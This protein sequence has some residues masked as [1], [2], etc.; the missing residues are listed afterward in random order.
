MSITWCLSLLL[1]LSISPIFWNV[2]SFMEQPQ[3]I[4]FFNIALVTESLHCQKKEKKI[5]HRFC[6]EKW[7]HLNY[8]VTYKMYVIQ[9]IPFLVC[10]IDWPYS[11]NHYEQG[12]I[13][14]MFHVSTGLFSPLYPAVMQT[15]KF[16]SLSKFIILVIL[17]TRWYKRWV[18]PMRYE[19]PRW[20]L[21]LGHEYAH[22]WTQY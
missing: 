18:F 10:I 2:L 11:R 3:L 15:I 16:I 1:L 12:N 20:I 19:D 21:C 6:L 22:K 4:F 5:S 7:W 9:N 14:W 8:V 17:S 13:E